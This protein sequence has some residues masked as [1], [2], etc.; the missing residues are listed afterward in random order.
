MLLAAA[1]LVAGRLGLLLAH[2]SGYPTPVWPASGIAL[3]ALLVGGYRLWPGVFI[4]AFL[5]NMTAGRPS[6]ADAELSLLGVSAMLALGSTVA[7][8][9]AAH[10]ANR[11]FINDPALVEDRTIYRLLLVGGLVASTIAATAGTAGLLAGGTVEAAETGFT[12]LTWWSGDALGVAIFTP[13]V[14]I[15]VGRPRTVWRRRVLSLGVPLVLIAATLT[16]AYGT[17]N[18]QEDRRV[19]AEFERSTS[20]LA[21]ALDKQL[22]LAVGA[23]QATADLYAASGGHDSHRFRQFA[24][25]MLGRTPALHALGW[26]PVVP[27]AQREVLERRI[28]MDHNTPGLRF[29][30]RDSAGQ[31]TTA[32]RRDRYVVVEAIEPWGGNGDAVAFDVASD[33]IRRQALDRATDSGRPTATAPLRLVQNHQRS[34]GLL[35]FVPIYRDTTAGTGPPATIEARRASITGFVTGVFRADEVIELALDQAGIELSQVC[36]IDGETG[37]PEQ[38]FAAYRLGLDGPGS[39][40]RLPTPEAKPNTHKRATR[41][42]DFAGRTWKLE[43]SSAEGY[44]THTRST[45]AWLLVGGALLLSYVLVGFLLLITSRGGLA[46]ARANQLA[47]VNTTL[48]QE[49]RQRIA[50]EKA[51]NVAKERAETTLRAIGDAVIT[52][53]EGGIVEYLSPVAERLT[54]W[55]TQAASGQPI[56]SVFRLVDEDTSQ[57]LADPIARCLAGGSPD[58]H[59]ERSLLVSRHGEFRAVQGSL[60]PILDSDGAVLGAIVVFRDVTEARRLAREA[61]YQASHDPLTGLVNRREFE[62]RLQRA[63]DRSVHS[64]EHGLCFLDLDGFKSVNDTAGHSAGDELL[65]RISGLLLGEVRSR[66]T[67]ARLGGDEFGLLLENCPL[68][69]A[70]EV[71]E[72]IVASIKENPFVW[73]GS[74]FHVGVSVGLVPITSQVGSTDEL[75]ALA[76]AACYSAKKRGKGCVHIHSGE[77]SATPELVHAFANADRVRQRLSEGR[78][79]LY[80]QPIAPLGPGPAGREWY[81]LLLRLNTC[82]GVISASGFIKTAERNGT[83]AGLDRWVIENALNGCGKDGGDAAGGP[84]VS[85]NVSGASFADPTLIPFILERLERGSVAPQQVCLELTERAAAQSFEAACTFVEASRNAGL[86]VALDQ[87]G[88]GPGSLANLTRLHVDVVKI[89]G[90]LVRHVADNVAQR[91][92][93][94]A[95]TGLGHSLGMSVVGSWAETDD[96]VAVLRDCGVDYAQGNAFAAP[97]PAPAA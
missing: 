96:C 6:A 22:A 10:A 33:P 47:A 57:P 31:L 92:V 27:H 59:G 61:S 87:Y 2:P 37:K 46:E 83:I 74:T 38:V 60:A 97:A 32:G 70:T 28:A 25:E 44:L 42:Y 88:T 12:W 49:V 71:A 8:G 21:D 89:D 54:G 13:L 14:L 65:R 77:T 58:D 66:D 79:E 20:T 72:R 73:L 76:D 69:Q 81:E 90:R 24:K 68:E 40:R 3:G 23:I 18:T 19:H 30:E 63:L 94:K 15:I 82:D 36:A 43:I 45:G 1:Y 85:I 48:R 34:T 39:W 17:H 75:L 55:T 95:I 9:F 86:M 16:V 52:T 29:T 50:T 64:G 84:R 35:L 53:D 26:D 41:R 62:R 11:T 91:M 67:L 56:A 78:F 4:G 5:V 93:V 51:L 80:R 7:A